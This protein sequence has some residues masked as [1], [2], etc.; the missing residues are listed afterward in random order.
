M[1]MVHYDGRLEDGEPVSDRDDV[2]PTNFQPSY[3]DDGE[4]GAK[5]EVRDGTDED[6]RYWEDHFEEIP[7]DLEDVKGFKMNLL[8]QSGN[9]F[10]PD[11]YNDDAKDARVTFEVVNTGP[12]P[13]RIHT[14]GFLE[15]ASLKN[16]LGADDTDIS[17][18][19]VR[20]GEGGRV[21][22]AGDIIDWEEYSI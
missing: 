21:T 14:A 10:L 11:S 22:I 3:V 1:R 18:G 13:V 20:I 4:H 12:N 5:L 9:P 19:V 8:N 6:F 2:D 17:D 15:N 16:A 7:D